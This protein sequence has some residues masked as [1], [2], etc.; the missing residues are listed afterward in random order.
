MPKAGNGRGFSPLRL[1]GWKPAKANGGD[2]CRDNKRAP[3]QTFALEANLNLHN[4]QTEYDSHSIKGWRT[5][6]Q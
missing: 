5:E 2:I 4:W 6:K 1:Q 3:L